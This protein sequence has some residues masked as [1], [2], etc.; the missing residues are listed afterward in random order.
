MQI[1]TYIHTY[2]S[3][4]NMWTQSFLFQAQMHRLNEYNINKFSITIRINCR[5]NLMGR[6]IGYYLEWLKPNCTFVKWKILIE[7]IVGRRFNAFPIP[8][9]PFYLTHEF[10]VC[11]LKK[12][13][14]WLSNWSFSHI[15]NFFGPIIVESVYRLDLSIAGNALLP[16]P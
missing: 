4:T 16:S 1:H 7:I 14:T 3:P 2:Y 11:S 10:P 9:Y 13:D 5:N 12:S 6:N 8:H 15:H